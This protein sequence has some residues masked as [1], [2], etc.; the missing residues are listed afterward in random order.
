MDHADHVALIRAGVPG[1][2]GTWADLGSGWGA[3]T[4]ALADLIGPTGQIFSV[5][6]DRRVL[7]EQEQAMRARFPAAQ[8]KYQVADFAQPLAFP[9]LDGVVMANAL[10]FQRDKLPVLTRIKAMLKPGGRLILVEY[11]SDQGNPWVPFPLAYATWAAL[12]ARAGF[13]ETRQ[14]A[15]VPSRFLR[16]IYAALSI[17]P[18][19]AIGE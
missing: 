7:A 4:L 14:I 12:A 6:R 19:T 15:S 10:H 16:E 3:F 11:N 9:P 5:D 2:G 18:L 13:A 17:R 8:V 1:Q